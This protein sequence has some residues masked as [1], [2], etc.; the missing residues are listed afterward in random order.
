[1][2]LAIYDNEEEQFTS[3]RGGGNAEIRVYNSFGSFKGKERSAGIPT[4]SLKGGG[5][6][7]Y[8]KNAER[9]IGASLERIE[10][11]LK[12]GRYSTDEYASLGTGIFEVDETVKKEIV[13]GIYRAA[14]WYNVAVEPSAYRADDGSTHSEK[15][16]SADIES[17]QEQQEQSDVVGAIESFLLE[18]TKQVSLIDLIMKWA[19][20]GKQ[21]RPAGWLPLRRDLPV[22]GS[23]SRI[24][25]SWGSTA[26][27]AGGSSGKCRG[28]VGAGQWG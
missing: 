22:T 19:P 25:Q 28:S 1:M 27:P 11:L 3:K 2:V 8:S 5:Y 6:R 17:S 15:R 14:R 26:G 18:Y 12:T 9:N 4:G 21:E 10:A 20:Q 13:K 24:N 7:S 16:I 23:S